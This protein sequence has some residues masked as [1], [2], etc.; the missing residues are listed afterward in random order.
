MPSAPII[1]NAA[2]E[3][4]VE[5]FLSKNIAFFDI[6]KYIMLLLKDKKYKNML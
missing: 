2:N 5:Q 6:F 4:L 1:I 3:V